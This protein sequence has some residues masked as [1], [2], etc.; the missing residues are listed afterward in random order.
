MVVHR[1][2]M[3]AVR[4]NAR[5]IGIPA[6]DV[7]PSRRKLKKI[8]VRVPGARERWVAA[9]HTDYADYTTHRD[10]ARRASYLKR[11]RGMPHPKW[12]PN[13]IAINLLWM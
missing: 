6:R 2:N 9:G 11:A 3:R 10:R 1:P 7:R 5:R 8:E 12:S 4:R 13:F